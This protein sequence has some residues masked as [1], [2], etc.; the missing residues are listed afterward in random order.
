M[1][2]L[3]LKILVNWYSGNLESFSTVKLGT[4]LRKG[5]LKIENQ[6]VYTE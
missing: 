6:T 1:A 4:H 5:M 2:P 3:Q